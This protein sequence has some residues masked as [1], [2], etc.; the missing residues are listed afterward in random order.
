MQPLRVTICWVVIAALASWATPA[1]AAAAPSSDVA[2]PIASSDLPVIDNGYLDGQLAFMGANYLMRYSGFDGPPGDLNPADGNLPPQVNGWQEFFEHWKE[3]VT[4]PNV[5]GAFAR[6]VDVSDHLFQPSAGDFFGASG[7]GDTPYMGDVRVAT[8]AGQSCPGQTTLIAGHPDSTPGLNSGNGS[9]YDDTSGVTMGMA[10]LQ[11]LS[12][13]WE[14]NGT[15]PARTIKVALFDAEEIG[16]VGS[17]FYADN[18]IPTGPQGQVVLVGNMDQN[19]LEYPAYPQGTT[20][21]TWTPGP[22]Y[23][24]INAS[25]IKDFSIYGPNASTPSPGIAANMPA[26]LHFR[27]A[28]DAEVHQAFANLGAKY[29]FSLPLDSPAEQGATVSAYEP[30]DIAKYSPVQ[31]D[32]LG[33]TDQVPFLALG[34]PGYGVLGAYD[35]N[36]QE[37]VVGGTPL[38][39]LGDAGLF[40]QQAGY[41]TPEDNLTHLNFLADGTA[42]ATTVSVGLQR[43]LELPATWTTYLFARPE[44]AGGVTR[45]AAP[46]AYYEALP[47]KPGVGTPIGFE[48]GGSVSRA[49]G[50]LRYYW[51]LGDGTHLVGKSVQHAY[52]AAGYYDAKLVVVD[53]R[54]RATGYQTSIKVGQTTA[55]AP[56]SNPCG[57]MTLTD[58]LTV[59]RAAGGTVRAVKP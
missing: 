50:T 39:P 34:V 19:G 3:Q 35:S 32:T 43:A 38:S 11:A 6:A 4:D 54:G 56:D 14:A 2:G 7:T 46:I 16:L 53:R 23:T 20:T 52:A 29:G 1:L 21:S 25:P 9:V 10:E 47:A 33:R 55:T 18:L 13:W 45:S 17:Q 5:M 24:N 51:D 49:G 59:V 41:D 30:G 28:L 26:I 31:D 36:P 40:S 12:R 8:I 42:N 58:A 22:W 37:D 57:T 48:A 44:Y 27:A 15:W